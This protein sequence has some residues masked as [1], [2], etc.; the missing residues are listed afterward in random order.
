MH[1]NLHPKEGILFF[2]P[3]IKTVKIHRLSRIL[4]FSVT[5]TGTGIPEDSLGKIFDRFYQVESSVKKEGGG[6]GIG[7]SLARDMARLMHGEITVESEICK[8][9]IFS[10]QIPLGKDHLD[11]SEFILTKGIREFSAFVPEL[12]ENRKEVRQEKE[13]ISKDEK[14]ILLIVEDNRDIRMQLADNFN[15]EYIIVEAI[16]GVAGLK[17]ATEMIPDLVI[18]DL[19]MP[20]M[21]GIGALPQAEK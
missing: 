14:P 16:D 4:V 5:D 7:L 6:T 21:D 15:R 12:H 20:R 8:G 3:G 18:T 2:L 9:S 1:L 17:K 13:V 10:V 11:E 19:M